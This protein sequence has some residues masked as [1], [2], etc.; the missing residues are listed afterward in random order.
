MKMTDM[1]TTQIMR[2]F[3]TV[4]RKQ[5]QMEVGFVGL[6]EGNSR[7]ILSLSTH[8]TSTSPICEGDTHDLDATYCAHIS[9]NQIPGIIVDT[10]KN[11]V[12]NALALTRKLDIRSY[13]GAT[14][15]SASGHNHGT[16]CC[17]NNSP[18]RGGK[19]S[20]NAEVL[21]ALADAAG[22]IL[23]SG[24]M[25]GHIHKHVF[26]KIKSTIISNNVEILFQPILLVP[27]NRV[28]GFE[29]LTG[30]A[31]IDTT[32]TSDWF[33]T[34][35]E[36]GLGVELELAC[37]KQALAYLQRFSSD[38]YLSVNVSPEAIFDPRITELLARHDLE[39][40]MLE[41]TEHEKVED[42]ATLKA[43]LAPLKHQGLRV[44]IDDAGAGYASLKH[45]LEIDADKIKLDISLIEDI[46]LDRRR[47]ALAS[48]LVTFAN[49]IGSTVLA[50]G[51]EN[52]RQLQ[53]LT[54]LGVEKIQGYYIS[55][56]LAAE[57]AIRAASNASTR[58]RHEPPQPD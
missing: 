49:A 55:P 6:F 4:A 30:F 37:L 18:L 52:T 12:T 23:D 53:A 51:V 7:K 27:E 35:A 34:A 19:D 57:A 42:Y 9:N 38:Q 31:H 32:P 14:I 20:V 28:I 50:E 10:H 36:C 17:Y 58:L 8:H 24:G 56:P 2:I 40:V 46:H 13:V 3:A 43:I 44:A 33:E 29:A 47:Y 15:T 1:T 25:Q 54:G 5:L 48:A 45:I 16:I 11:K 41:I 26:E 39:R 21:K 22:A